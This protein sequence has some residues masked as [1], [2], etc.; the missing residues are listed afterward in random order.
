MATSVVPTRRGS[1]SPVSRAVMALI[2]ETA[3]QQRLG[4]CW[5]FHPTSD[6]P[7]RSAALPR[8]IR[9]FSKER[10]AT[11]GHP[12]TAPASRSEEPAVTLT[13]TA[14]PAGPVAIDT[15]A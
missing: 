13:D 1:A 11:S 5:E 10:S 9:G 3:A 7:G 8:M 14:S 4:H 6:P 2:V 12:D 15:G